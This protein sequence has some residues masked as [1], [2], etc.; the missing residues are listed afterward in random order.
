MSA[1]CARAIDLCKN[2]ERG[3]RLFMIKP[4]RA[5][6]ERGSLASAQAL[7][8]GAAIRRGKHDAAPAPVHLSLS[9]AD[10][11]NL[12]IFVH[13]KEQLNLVPASTLKIVLDL[14]IPA[15]AVELNRASMGNGV[16]Q[17][18]VAVVFSLDRHLSAIPLEPQ[19]TRFRLFPP[20][21]P[22]CHFR[23]IL[24]VHA[25]SVVCRRAAKITPPLR[26]RMVG[27]SPCVDQE[28][29]V[30]NGEPKRQRVRMAM[31]RYARKP[32]RTKIHQE[33][34]AFIITTQARQPGVR[35]QL[36]RL[37]RGLRGAAIP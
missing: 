33:T 25:G 7:P 26:M 18:R 6:T 37:G 21:K 14:K 3:D 11:E 2:A 36:A 23:L 8:P 27:I 12:G 10:R 19:Q 16:F 20:Q 29:V 4:L 22:T 28:V 24:S 13:M 30:A 34:Y 31:R 32:E 17:A 1:D 9:V 35:K 5:P 15:G